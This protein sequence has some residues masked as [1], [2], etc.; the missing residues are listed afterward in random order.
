V[1]KKDSRGGGL[2]GPGQI[3]RVLEVLCRKSSALLL[4]PASSDESRLKSWWWWQQQL[5][6]PMA[7][8][9]GP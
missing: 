1:C 6:G 5:E 2:G 8:F 4:K 3:W 9:S 7:A